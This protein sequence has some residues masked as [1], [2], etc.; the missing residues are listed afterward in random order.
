MLARTDLLLEQKR[1]EILQ[2]SRSARLLPTR[3]H[4]VLGLHMYACFI[5]Q[6]ESL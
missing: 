3:E 5:E 1:A 6:F 4:D 2:N